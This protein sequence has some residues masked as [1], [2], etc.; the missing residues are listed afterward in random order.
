[1]IQ[2]LPT[3]PGNPGRSSQ[4]NLKFFKEQPPNPAKIGLNERAG[5]GRKALLAA[6]FSVG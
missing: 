6:N 1:M 3:S 4:K 2:R 5:I